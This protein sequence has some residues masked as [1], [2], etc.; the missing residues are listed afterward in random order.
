[1]RFIE[2][3]DAIVTALGLKLNPQPTV[4]VPNPPRPVRM[5]ARFGGQVTAD[6]L[7]RVAVNAPA[8]LVTVLA[9]PSDPVTPIRVRPS[10]AV[11]VITK[12]GKE[13]DAEDAKTITKDVQALLLVQSVLT[14]VNGNRWNL[15]YTGDTLNLRADNLFSARSAQGGVAIWSVRWDQPMDLPEDVS[16]SDI[17]PFVTANLTWELSDG[18]TP[19]EGGDAADTV[20]LDQPPEAP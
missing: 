4:E 14:V 15:E 12:G 10:V 16:A 6:E 8:I 11:F 20:T 9:V 3:L 13:S 17:E 7:M 5:I 1:M 2:L 19:P 18:T